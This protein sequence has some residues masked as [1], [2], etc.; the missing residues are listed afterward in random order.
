MPFIFPYLSTQRIPFFFHGERN[1]SRS[2][3]YFMAV[4]FFP[5]NSKAWF[6]AHLFRLKMRSD[7]IHNDN[8]VDEYL[9]AQCCFHNQ[10]C[11]SISSRSSSKRCRPQHG[12]DRNDE[13]IRVKKSNVSDKNCENFVGM[14]SRRR[15]NRE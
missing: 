13:L 2:N 8:D 5:R 6:G 12:F 7:L 11:I 4:A 14:N 3:V 15:N 9:C 10:K 1:T